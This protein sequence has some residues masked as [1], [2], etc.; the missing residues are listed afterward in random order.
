MN[1]NTGNGPRPSDNL[2][3]EIV[4]TLETCGVSW[5][6]YQLYNVVDVEAVEQLMASTGDGGVEICFAVEGIPLS[7][8]PDGV[9]VLLGSHSGS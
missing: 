1:S 3:T 9:D 5:D 4:E 7:V 2:V 8:T 6:D